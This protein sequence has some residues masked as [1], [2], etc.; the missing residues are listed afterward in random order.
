MGTITDI[1]TILNKVEEYMQNMH[2]DLPLQ[3]DSNYWIQYNLMDAFA[4][5]GQNPGLEYGSEYCWLPVNLNNH[6]NADI[7]KT[8]MKIGPSMEVYPQDGVKVEGTNTYISRDLALQEGLPFIE[9]SFAQGIHYLVT[10]PLEFR[11]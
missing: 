4:A 2:G 1:K 11:V 9:H 7:L 8:R 10:L 3:D 6:P 5:F